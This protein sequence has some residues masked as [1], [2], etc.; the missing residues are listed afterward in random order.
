M[1]AIPGPWSELTRNTL[2]TLEEKEIGKHI[3]WTDTRARDFQMVASAIY[4]LHKPSRAFPGAGVLQ[5]FLQ[6]STEKPNEELKM[7]VRDVFGIF[8]ALF[9]P[10]FRHIFTTP[11]KTSPIEFCLIPEAICKYMSTQTLEQIAKGIEAMRADVR[12]K[13]DDIRS[14]TKVSKTLR[15]FIDKNW[16]GT[17]G[18]KGGETALTMIR[19]NRAESDSQRKR[20]RDCDEE[21]TEKQKVSSST[22]VKSEESSP[23]VV[24]SSNQS[25]MSSSRASSSTASTM[26][27]LQPPSA[28]SSSAKGVNRLAKLQAAAARE[29]SESNTPSLQSASL[30]PGTPSTPQSNGSIPQFQAQPIYPQLNFQPADPRIVQSILARSS[31]TSS[32]AVEMAPPNGVFVTPSNMMPYTFNPMSTS[33]SDPS[34]LQHPNHQ[35]LTPNGSRYSPGSVSAPPGPVSGGFAPSSTPASTPIGTETA[36]LRPPSSSVGKS[37]RSPNGMVANASA[38]PVQGPGSGSDRRTPSGQNGVYQNEKRTSGDFRP[39]SSSGLARSNQ[40]R[41]W[42]RD[43][44]RER[45]N[46]WGPNRGRH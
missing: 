2:R 17:K 15:T 21:S 16:P 24:K 3:E 27:P 25:A 44:E 9:D 18:K 31:N 43:K 26:K 38:S 10:K 4:L 6:S 34:A 11:T 41:D 7:R 40:H 33:A 30:P 20:K 28:P 36:D 8:C 37:L 19:A 42:D 1:Q 32:P 13:H 12:T 39:P 35:Q 29:R 14:N 23:K 22:R 5:T 46:G 45:D